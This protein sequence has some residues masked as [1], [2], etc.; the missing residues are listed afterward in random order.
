MH[1][2]V[3]HP[4]I[5]PLKIGTSL[6]I[7]PPYSMVKHDWDTPKKSIPK[8]INGLE[9][10]RAIYGAFTEAVWNPTFE[11]TVK[12]DH[13]EIKMEPENHG[14]PL[15][16]LGEFSRMFMKMKPN[17]LQP[18]FV[19]NVFCEGYNDPKT[20]QFCI[21]YSIPLSETEEWKKIYL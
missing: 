21:L 8:G 20:H 4:K 17:E 3:I 11:N 1:P 10:R 7:D 13:K 6:Y 14:E 5:I 15:N 9:L 19:G 12:I 18:V 2:N 16:I